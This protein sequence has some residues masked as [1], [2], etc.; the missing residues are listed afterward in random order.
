MTQCLEL[1]RVDRGLYQYI[2]IKK[3]RLHR[4][5]QTIINHGRGCLENTPLLKTYKMN[6]IM[7]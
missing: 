7:Y 3:N 6:K 2:S 1:W 4:P 5:L